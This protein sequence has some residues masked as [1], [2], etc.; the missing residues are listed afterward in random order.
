MVFFRRGAAFLALITPFVWGGLVTEAGAQGSAASDQAALAAL[1][2][3]TGG[4][5]WENSTNWKTNAPLNQWFGVQTDAAGRVIEIRLRENALKG[6][7]PTALRNLDR[8]GTLELGGNDLTGAVPSWLGELS[9]LRAL[10]LWGN[11]LTRTIPAALQNLSRLDFLNLSGNNLTGQVPTWLGDLS[12]LWLLWLGGTNSRPGPG[13]SPEPEQTPVT[14][15][16]LE[17]IDG[18]HPHLAGRN[19]QPP[20]ACGSR[21]MN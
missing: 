9:N 1:Y 14:E 16:R 17:P 8:L 21:A 10:A 18:H 7:L 15:P 20:D 5:T 11:E 6:S 19:V 13:Q 4:A 3:A 2:D 12:N